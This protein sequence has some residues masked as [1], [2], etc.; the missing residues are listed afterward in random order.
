MKLTPVHSTYLKKIDAFV[1]RGEL[2]WL[3][4]VKQKRVG[5]SIIYDKYLGTKLKAR[6][7]S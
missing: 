7:M 6:I 1:S 4:G 2:N 5:T 3:L